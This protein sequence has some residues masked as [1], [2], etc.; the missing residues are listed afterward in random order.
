[1]NNADVGKFQ[2]ATAII[3]YYLNYRNAFHVANRLMPRL[4]GHIYLLTPRD[5]EETTY[6]GLNVDD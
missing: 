4:F 6:V 5:G 3:D 1:M 2:T